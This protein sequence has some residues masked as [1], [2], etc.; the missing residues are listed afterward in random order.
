MLEAY[1]LVSKRH[2]AGYAT[3]PRMDRIRR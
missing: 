3:S 1:G 2:F